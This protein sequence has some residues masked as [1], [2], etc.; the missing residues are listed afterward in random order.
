MGRCDLID[1]SSREEDSFQDL[2]ALMSKLSS[3]KDR[4]SRACVAFR[5]D[6]QLLDAADRG[7]GPRKKEDYVHAIACRCMVFEADLKV[8]A[9]DRSKELW[10][11]LKPKKQ[12]QDRFHRAQR[13]SWS[14]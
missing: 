1:I 4:I 2:W 3:R 10:A 9:V 14:R 8:S 7:P 12:F 11:V 13:P 6:E 5:E